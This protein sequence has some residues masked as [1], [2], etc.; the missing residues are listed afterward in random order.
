MFSNNRDKRILIKITQVV[1]LRRF[2]LY[3]RYFHAQLTLTWDKNE[4]SSSIFSKSNL[5]FR[6]CYEQNN[7]EVRISIY[8]I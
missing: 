4:L 1:F 8:G 6:G 3:V 7:D 5:F 2:V